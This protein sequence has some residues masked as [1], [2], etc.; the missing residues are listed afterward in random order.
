MSLS[1][2]KAAVYDR[3]IADG[4]LP[5][6]YFDNVESS[7]LPL[8]PVANHLRPFVLPSATNTIDLVDLDQEVGIIQV[9][10]YVGKGQGEIVSTD[11]ASTIL[12]L[13]ARP[14]NLTELRIDD[15]GSIAPP[16]YDG[17]WYITPVTIPY[18]NLC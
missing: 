16:F 3:L 11:I 1:A 7:T 12:A 14:L 5:P 8:P 2:I 6:L 4:S 10:I 17:G 18:Q 9:S 13:F 15:A